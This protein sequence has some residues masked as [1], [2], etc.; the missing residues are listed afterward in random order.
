VSGETAV[1]R[2]FGT[3]VAGD[4]TATVAWSAQGPS[5][6][7]YL[8]Y[9]RAAAVDGS[10]GAIRTISVPQAGVA[11]STASSPSL[12]SSKDGIT[13][14]WLESTYDSDI[15]FNDPYAPPPKAGD[16]CV[17]LQDVK[18][19]QITTGGSLGPI[20]TLAHRQASYPADGPFGG[21]GGAFVSYGGPE[22]SLGPGGAVTVIWSEAS[23]APG[24]SSYGY[25]YDD[26][27]CVADHTVKW[28]RL[29][30]AGAPAAP[31]ADLFTIHTTG[32]GVAQSLI[33]VHGAADANGVVTVVLANRS[34]AED[35]ACP[36]GKTTV[37]TRRIAANGTLSP[38]QQIDEGCGW[39]EPKVAVAPAGAAAVVWAWTDAESTNQIRYSRIPSGGVPGAAQPLVTPAAEMEIAAPDVDFGV[40]AATAIWGAD[41]AV[42]SRPIPLSGALGAVRTL[43]AAPASSRLDSIDLALSTTGGAAIWEAGKTTSGRLETAVKAVELQPDGTPSS[44]RTLLSPNRWDHGA[45]AVIGSGGNLVA[46]W[47]L[48]VPRA[49]AI[50]VARPTASAS[51]ANDAFSAA[52]EI[53]GA[54]PR[55]ASGA[56]D[57]ATK[58]AGEPNHAGDS[59]GA[60]LWYSW[61]PASNGPVTISTCSADSLDTLLGVYT[62]SA[63]G[64]LTEVRSDDDSANSS[65][66]TGDSEVRFNAAAGTAYRIAVDGKGGSKGSFALAVAK[67]P[68]SLANDDF[69]QARQVGPSLPWSTSGSNNGATKQAGE[70][71]HAG[72]AG[73][74]SLW[75]SWTPISNAEVAIFACASGFDPLLAVYTGPDVAHLTAVASD[76]DGAGLTGCSASDSEARFNALAGVT[77]RIAVDAKGTGR[78]FFS[79]QLLGHSAN[80]D[81]SSPVT[82]FGTSSFTSVDNRLATKQAGEPNHAGNSGGASLWY[83][84]TPSVA[85][86]V[87]ISTCSFGNVDPLL[88]VYKGTTIGG[89][90]ELVSSDDGGGCTSHDARV[91]FTVAA[92][93]TYRIAVDSKSGQTGFFSFS[94]VPRPVNDN[95][96][97]SVSLGPGAAQVSSSNQTGGKEPGE[98]N[99]AGD[100]GGA[101]VWYSWTAAKPGKVRVA[102]CS[103]G[104]LDSL[105]GVY[106]G[107]AVDALVEVASN[108]NAPGSGCSSGSSSLAFNA[109]AGTTYRFAV[110]G[111]KGSQGSFSL[112]VEPGPDN[113]GF[114]A[115][116]MLQGQPPL[117]ISGNNR[118]AIKEPGEPNHAGNA[119]GASVWYSWTAASSGTVGVSACPSGLLQPL[120]GVYT[121][122]ALNQLAEVPGQSAATS[123][124]TG[125]REIRFKAVTGTTYRIALDGR[126]GSEG[127]FSLELLAPP[128]ND[129]FATAR[130]LGP[131]LPESSY[132]TNRLATKQAG[133]PTHAG[134]AGGASV[135]YSWTPQA[136]GPVEVE[137]CSFGQLDPLIGVYTG[138]SFGALSAEKTVAGGA[139]SECFGKSYAVVV[140]AVAGV[141]YRIAIDGRD[142]SEGTFQ[143][144]LR[145]RPA[146][147]LFASAEQLPAGLPGFAFGNNH[148]AGK[149]PGEP[150]H[151]GNPGGGSVWYSWTATASEPVTLYACSYGSFKPLLA[152]YTGSAVNQLTEVAR[153]AGS[154]SFE[155][156]SGDSK[157]SFPAVAGATYRIAVDGRD[158]SSGYFELRLRHK[159]PDND[160]FANATAI[161][162][163]QALVAG[164]THDA[165][166]QTGEYMGIASPAHSVWY[167]WTAPESGK[168][169]LHTCSDSGGPMDV[170]VYTGASL[171]SLTP[172]ASDAPFLGAC[173]PAGGGGAPQAA[174]G[175]VAL[176]FS[177]VAGTTYRISVDAPIT[178]FP[179]SRGEGGPFV[180]SVNGPANDLRA[181]AERLTG[182][183]SVVRSSLGATREAGEAVH[184]GD[185]GG[186]S[187]WF[188]WFAVASGPATIDTCGSAF[189][190]LL[191]VEK[192]DFTAVASNDNSSTCGAGST[193]S[194]VSFNAVEGTDYLIAADGK[195]GASGAVHLHVGFNFPDTTPPETVASVTTAIN[196]SQLYFFVTP[197]EPGSSF[198]CALD[199][200]PFGSCGEDLSGA[201]YREFKLSGLVEGPHVLEVREV[202]LAGNADPTPSKN[203]FAVDT[204]PPQTTISAGPEGL[205]RSVGSFSFFASESSARFECALDEGSFSSCSSPFGP[206][207]P[208]EG[209]HV[210]KARAI[211]NA[212]NVDPSPAAR[213]FT[214]DLTPPVVT[215]DQGPSG[216]VETSTVAFA[217]SANEPA[218]FGCELD[219]KFVAG[220]K[221][222]ASFSALADG[223]H[224]FSLSA[225]D[226]AGNEGA[227]LSRKFHVEARPPETTI[228]S[229]PAA[230][231]SA[232]SASFKFISNEQESSFECSL[233]KEPFAACASPHTRSG[234]AEGQHALKV[235]AVDLAGKPDPTPAEYSWAVDTTPPNT[236]IASGPNGLTH[237]TGPFSFSSNE[238]GT[239]YECAVDGL[240]QFSSCGFDYMLPVHT[241]GSHSLQV[242]AVDRAGNIDPTPAERKIV[243][244]TVAPVTEIT[245]GPP[246]LTGADV[247]VEFEVDDE[248]ATAQC[249]LDDFSG[250]C[251]SPLVLKGLEDGP[252]TIKVRA[253]DAAGNEG[254]F[255]KVDF[256]VDEQPPDT[257]IAYA[258]AEYTNSSTATVGFGGTADAVE[259]Q[260]ALDDAPLG[261]CA[262]EVT[263]EGLADGRHRVRAVAIDGVG[264]I[265]ATPAEVEFVVDTVAP[266]TTIAKGPSG[267]VHNPQAPFEFESSELGGFECALDAGEFGS[268]DAAIHDHHVGDHVF[269]VRAYDLAGNV[270]PT[271]AEHP[272]SIANQDPVP[273]LSIDQAEGGAPLQV[274]AAVSGA[275]ADG[276]ELGYELQWGDGARS[277]GPLPAG[278]ASHTY[279]AAGVYVVRLEVEDDYGSAVVTRTVTVSPPEPLAARAGDDLTVVAGE[280]IVLDGGNSRP[281]Q[282]IDGFAWSFGDGGS[283]SGAV[284]KHVYDQ[285]GHYEAELTVSRPGDSSSDKVSIDVISPPPGERVEISVKGDGAPLAGAEV[286]VMLADGRKVHAFSGTSGIARLRGLADGAYEAY[287]YSDGYLP[288]K[289]DLTVAGGNGEAAIEMHSGELATATVDSHPMTL[290]EI[291]AAG[292]DPSDPDNQ[293][294][295]QFEVHLNLQPWWA[296]GSVISRSFGGMVGRGGFISPSCQQVTR[297]ICRTGFGSG[298]GAVYT[299]T[300]WIDGAGPVLSSLVIPFRA[301]FLKEFYEVSMI[302]QNLA[303]PGFTLQN[304]TALID[305]PGGMSLAPTAKPQSSTVAVPDIPGGGSA[306]MNW[307]LRGDVEGEYNL[308]A[309]YGG[310]LEP[311]GRSVSLEGRTTEPIKVWGGSALKLEVDVDEAV[312]D[313][314]PYTVFVKLKNVADVS[315]YNPTVELLK[316]GRAGYIEQ[317]QQQ[318]SY[319]V[320]ELAPGATQVTGPFIIV[321][322][323][324]GKI[325]LAKSFIRKT[326]GDV[327]LGGTIVTH[328]RV[329]SFHDTPKVE[330]RGYGTKLVLDWE[331]VAGASGYSEF[332]TPDRETD[333]PAEPLSV[334]QLDPT[335]VVID[336]V[337][338]STP[339]FYGISS[340]LGVPAMV[341]PL[342]I[343]SGETNH[344]WPKVSLDAPDRCDQ[345]D[346]TVHLNFEALD[347]PLASYEVQIN[348]KSTG[349]PRPLSGLSGST[350][351]QVPLPTASDTE[352]EVNV[353]VIVHDD[354]GNQ[355]ALSEYLGCNY[356][357]LGDSY[358]SGEGVPPFE[359][360][361]DLNGC[362]RSTRAYSELVRKQ[363]S[364]AAVGDQ[365]IF[366]ACSGAKLDEMTKPNA[367]GEPPQLNHLNSGTHLVTLSIGGNDLDFAEIIGDCVIAKALL[368]PT[369]RDDHAEDL[370]KGFKK[371]WKELPEVLR[372]IRSLA[373][374][375]RI[376]FVA[377][378]QIFPSFP[379]DPEDLLEFGIPTGGGPLASC[380]Q[381]LFDNVNPWDVVWLGGMQKKANA[382]IEEAVKTSGSGAEYVS[383]GDRFSGHDVCQEFD[384]WFNGGRISPR[385]YSFHPNAEGQEAMAE[386]VLEKLGQPRPHN[387]FQIHP[388]EVVHRIASVRGGPLG[389][390]V[391]SQVWPG[392]DVEL[393]LESPAG[394]VIDRTTDDDDVE[395]ELGPTFESYVVDKPES[396]AWTMTFKGLEVA[397]QGEPVSYEVASAETTIDTPPTALFTQSLDQA[398]PGQAIE[399]DGGESSDGDGELTDYEWNF[400]DGGKAAG[401]V[402]EHSFTSPGL[403]TARLL[404]R[405]DRGEADVAGQKPIWVRPDPTASADSYA[406][407]AGAGLHVDPAHGVMAND[408]IDRLG[409]DPRAEAVATTAHGSLSLAGDGGFEYL[410]GAGFSG[411]DTF[412]YRVIDAGGFTS[413]TAAVTVLVR[414]ASSSGPSGGAQGGTNPSTPRATPAAASAP[415]ETKIT[416]LTLLG[417][418]AKLWFSGRGGGPLHFACALDK[419]PF[420]PCTSPKAYAGLTSGRHSVR[421]RAQGPAATDS[422][423][424]LKRFTVKPAHR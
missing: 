396:G 361:S 5:G 347:F 165:T 142:G 88:A 6:S 101:S 421:V 290:D 84:W 39:T 268:C 181:R 368:D 81:F 375:A 230:E 327:D 27:G 344:E 358:S 78:G 258:P 24:C 267:P 278:T 319:S 99:H 129:D 279:T 414:A 333:F 214:L 133:E 79:L 205:V 53:S 339:R 66:S 345:R 70:P 298:G 151:A 324:S 294:V 173:G 336:G 132:D 92:G 1:Q 148:F 360:T 60:S 97:N 209:K 292:I 377:Y 417:R 131:G 158:G 179:Y 45:R 256:T 80:D 309:H 280:E 169:M 407:D 47:R 424:A 204:V 37:Q 265:D 29:D 207:Q 153:G 240:A 392:S 374:N 334:R 379:Y 200:G 384:P 381:I 306:K 115:A 406:A 405:D 226:T 164:S 168:V 68:A 98:P 32:F 95:F 238:S 34:G 403:Y 120:L 89:L 366:Y 185:P 408:T 44:V 340:K 297:R 222:P 22:L 130:A 104:S 239:T 38:L 355:R 357:A 23:F 178:S 317:P 146:N 399:F 67:L 160:D 10:L 52:E 286:M 59:G 197:D 73:G 330:A 386:A 192:S 343:A 233:D 182:G 7:E 202:D 147:D 304:G 4:G 175:S 16:E 289:G 72:N 260:C 288:A 307:V 199:S 157:V 228:Q 111:K 94:V 322:K 213:A 411:N 74:A 234:L 191:G 17:V 331:P 244:D 50:Q 242:R 269:R 65:C 172:A 126:D 308:A 75:Y 393:S 42:Q 35:P 159:P 277:E 275:D 284:V 180:L 54:L 402:V 341:H 41:G 250:S 203:L 48:A 281:L 127:S 195:S 420:K 363:G 63:V 166:A 371:V 137:V 285:P 206:A 3:A 118:N 389:R 318:R 96:A 383:M 125:G 58:Q 187:V 391:F 184:A 69:D 121:G 177:A 82:L 223:D 167:R 397:A 237:L 365:F 385:V 49:D 282:G 413:A 254:A 152:V 373:P 274:T 311:F 259:Y 144:Q 262:S 56:N 198:E 291:E 140:T 87:T 225:T 90:S 55:F 188:R 248:G 245:A 77:Y 350:T 353:A 136:S 243:L 310:S 112:N 422:T 13:V 354:D 114:A 236:A 162:Q 320:R 219:G 342:T 189:D 91:A 156:G 415:P 119:G 418:R 103:F 110:D 176:S 161:G 251:T 388:G 36:A 247:S 174:S 149:E 86:E 217:F 410:P 316:E 9:A 61:T 346:P 212:G 246:A 293:H 83:S 190:T 135:W 116:V 128:A 270:D 325:D 11:L 378:P 263:Y 105:L 224:V 338:P 276:D 348:G 400:D 423:P 221:S 261:D 356:V 145:G 287:A 124:C 404:V 25:S 367:R 76:D 102:A 249:W 26:E 300:E 51:V 8:I 301:S 395:H 40:S 21:A 64:Q 113:D 332:A 62:G 335:K 12:I 232:T 349:P 218:S 220:C 337:D 117:S 302:V 362:H 193:Q 266:Q 150:D 139:D 370:E 211:D 227:T 315:V 43:A 231:T 412:T 257:F 272:F 141:A 390:A 28:V 359:V 376:L 401:K 14:V 312:L 15:C 255:A 31:A 398:H 283:G 416:K 271:P 194:Q 155:C 321:P 183:A 215:I 295:Y 299:S 2:D 252:H 313:G 85:G 196:S 71:N 154:E 364:A 303:A 171:N 409:G 57:G 229:G 143:L 108:D 33:R 241:D 296:N 46:T 394:R 369:C 20:A 253:I 314:Y 208:T 134:N 264:N 201:G 419:A 107:S 326:A 122:S 93:V 235:R 380:H 329:P 170:H 216:V 138:A 109:T 123:Q 382:M 351:E 372:K 323:P 305:V 163:P 352:K 30:N 106:T 186:A 18:S 210:F 19:R 387:S 273:S 100:P 328:P